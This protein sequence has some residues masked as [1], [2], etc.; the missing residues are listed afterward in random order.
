MLIISVVVMMMQS[1]LSE[2]A[3]IVDSASLT[4][5]CQDPNAGQLMSSLN[6]AYGKMALDLVR[7]I[8][9]NLEKTNFS[10]ALEIIV[11]ESAASNLVKIGKT[12]CLRT[13]QIQWI[14]QPV[15]TQSMCPHHFVRV[16]R[17][18]RYP[19]KVWQAVCNCD[20]RLDLLPNTFSGYKCRPISILRPVLVRTDNCDPQTSLYIWK[21]K[22]EKVAISCAF[23]E[24][25][26]QN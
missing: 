6:E 15:N 5:S 11:P 12:A 2:S 23:M 10:S 4:R 9:K 25:L 13:S 3:S 24:H 21:M 7:G 1:L 20:Q 26:A 18:D 8:D 19:F 22:W 16:E 17:T 14:S